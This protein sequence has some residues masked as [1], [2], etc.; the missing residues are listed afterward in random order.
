[1]DDQHGD[2]VSL[3]EAARMLGVPEE[4]VGVMIDDGLLTPVVDGGETRVRRAEVL[5]AG[6][7]GA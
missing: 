3:A 4:Q 1:M 7:A 2:L 5:A 6:E